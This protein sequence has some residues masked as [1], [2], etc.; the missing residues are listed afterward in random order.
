MSDSNTTRRYLLSALG[1]SLPSATLLEIPLPAV[2]Q[3]GASQPHQRI[4][5]VRQFGAAG[6]GKTLDTPAINQAIEAAAG[7]SGGTVRFPSGSYLSYS[8]HLRSNIT[9]QLETGATSTLR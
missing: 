2:A 4:F 9:L 3:T 8:I 1:V 5:D 7:V 6:D